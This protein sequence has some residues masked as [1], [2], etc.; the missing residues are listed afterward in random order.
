MNATL[1]TMQRSERHRLYDGDA[2]KTFT[3]RCSGSVRLFGPEIEIIATPEFQRLDGMRQLGTAHLVFRSA[4]HTRF[5][6]SL[7]TLHEAQ[8]I[9]DAVNANPRGM[10]AIDDTGQ[11]LARLLALLHDLTHVPYGHTLEDEFLLLARHDD[12]AGRWARLLDNGPIGRILQDELGHRK[13]DQGASE[14]QLLNHA[15]RGGEQAIQALGRY[16][17]VVDIVTNTVCADALDYIPRDLTACGMPVAIGE[18]FLDYFVVVPESHPETRHRNRMALRLDKRGMPRPDVES[19]VHKLLEHRYELVERVFFH[20]GKNA[21]SAM[22]SRAVQ[23]LGLAEH[24]ENFDLLGD[25]MLRQVLITP[26]IAP[27]L[28]LVATADVQRRRLASRLA[29][30]VH[31]RRLYKLAY[32]GVPE[33]NVALRAKRISEEQG[34]SAPTRRAVED[35]L[36]AMAGL[37]AGEVLVHIPNPRML[38]KEGQVR[39]MLDNGEVVMLADWDRERSRRLEALSRAHERLWRVAVYV[40]PTASEAELGLLT[41]AA[42]DRFGLRPRYARQPAPNPYL[43]ELF[44]Q[45]AEERD[46]PAHLRTAAINRAVGAA[47]KAENEGQ[48][49]SHTR[50]AMLDLLDAAVAELGAAEQRPVGQTDLFGADG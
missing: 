1:R 39:V 18:R 11:R 23:D 24:E 7:G 30:E 2:I 20:H 25:D 50:G 28:G 21:A 10:E 45:Q 40:H 48:N 3:V 34:S 44:D 19:E 17:Y 13:T 37:T 43:G 32:L 36:A 9:I 35:D 22:L 8:R 6:H 12:N 15:L 38:A 42:E 14:L 27:L 5:E 41:A 46:W 4:N 16:A 26:T 29:R 33:E 47:A 31:E 49:V